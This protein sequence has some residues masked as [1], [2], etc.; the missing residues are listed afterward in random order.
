M[1][2]ITKLP[3]GKYR[4]R[5]MHRGKAYSVVV[6]Y[7]PGKIEAERIVLDQI[8][9]FPTG[10]MTLGEALE[11]FVA[12]RSIALS[13]STIR[14][15]NSMIRNLPDDDK[16]LILQ[17][18]DQK[19]MQLLVDRYAVHRSPKSVRNLVGFL[20]PALSRQGLHFDLTLPEKEKPDV[21]IP[22]DEDVR[23]LLEEAKGTRYYVPLSLA[24][25]GLRR[26]EICALT[27][28]D[29]DGQILRINKA[30]VQDEHQ[31]WVL[32][33]TKTAY[34]VRTVKIDAHLADMIRFQGF[35]YKGSPESINEWMLKTQEK[36]G[37][38]RYTLHKLRHYFASVCHSMGVPDKDIMSMGGWKTNA[39]LQRVYQHAME[40][41]LEKAADQ[42]ADRMA[43][44]L[45]RK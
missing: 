30:L 13:P 36:L 20:S 44:V 32:K 34:S 9:K 21:Y 29:L 11:S 16:D 23:A 33:S 45:E 25:Y 41:D 15:Y 40:K 18:L 35:I 2:T 38:N 3:S 27:I 43:S 8:R 19:T 14:T 6:D 31:Q 28:D 17:N 42:F 4:I 24:C 12:D 7:K 39:T 1:A 37:Q 22:S 10:R 5:K 26:G